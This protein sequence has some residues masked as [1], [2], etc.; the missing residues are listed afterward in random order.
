[1][2]PIVIYGAGGAGRELAY[3]LSLNKN[4][5]VVGFVDDTKNIIGRVINGIKIIGSNSYF[6]DNSV[7]V[8]VTILD[9]P[10]LRKQIINNLP[11]NLGFPSIQC[12]NSYISPDSIVGKGSVINI[13][14]CVQPNVQIGEF[15]W[16][17]GSCRIGHDVF[18]GNYSVLFSG[19]M[20][21]GNCHIGECCMIG[22]GAVLL[23]G[24]R[25]GN[26]AKVGAGAVVVK[27]VLDNITVV[28]NPAKD[29]TL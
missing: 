1:M 21:G 5:K 4:W 24:V 12:F 11:A 7:S 3:Q 22:S 14:S 8:I 28:G 9:K 19:I 10:A 26:N 18:I 20:V 27:D 17:N 25:I 16:V 29:I 13:F 23:P 2:K 6:N 15:V